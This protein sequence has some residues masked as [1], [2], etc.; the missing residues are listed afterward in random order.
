MSARLRFLHTG[1][2]QHGGVIVGH[3]DGRG[4][5]GAVF[6]ELLYAINVA[7]QAVEIDLEPLQGRGFVLHPV[8][9]AAGAA[10]KRPATLSRWDAARGRLSVPAR[11]ALVYVLE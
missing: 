7:P 8:H 1:P 5:A 3:L 2:A 4:L 10:D 11:T 6:A 9:R